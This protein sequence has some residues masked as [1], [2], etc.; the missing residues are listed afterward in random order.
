MDVKRLLNKKKDVK[1]TDCLSVFPM[2]AGLI[3]VPFYK[4]KYQDVWGICERPDEARDNGY[5]FFRYL[6]ENHPE[7][8]CVYAIDKKCSDY[9][10]VKDIGETV[11][12]G[13]VKHWSL[14]F[15]CKYLVSSQRFTPNGYLCT[16]LERAGF[17]Q[18]AHVFLQHGITINKPEYL[19]ADRRKVVLF[20]AA[21]QQEAEF[22]VRELGYKPEQVACTGFSRFDALHSFQ[23]KKNRI[24]IMPT[25]RKWLRL[26]SEGHSDTEG[27]VLSS[28]Y[29]K[30]WKELLNAPG[31]EALAETYGLEIVFVPHSNMKGLFDAR[32]MAGPHIQIADLDSVNLQELMKSSEM[33]I[34]D[35]SSIFFDMVYMKKPVI[36]YQ[37]DEDKFRKYHYEEGW[38]RYRDSKLGTVCT[39]G[40]EV[41]AALARVIRAD[42]QAD[43]AFLEEHRQIFQKYDGNNSQRI[44]N[45]IKSL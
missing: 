12:F 16:F 14:Y 42:Y 30:A 24:L 34:T 31:I 44:Y 36:F 33:L 7:Q 9:Q 1:L 27:N 26:R 4:R 13:S 32:Q 40:E 23:V 3:L 10:N 18:P 5:H 19:M 38:F 29:F 45:A 35:Y 39:T 8:Q 21:V 28:Q 37:F 41:T 25:W 22:V 17:F 6:A 43:E 11:Q 20:I 2:A 15:C